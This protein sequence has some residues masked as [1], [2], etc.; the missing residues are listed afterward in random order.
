MLL[1]QV[2]LVVVVV[3]IVIVAI[4]V[5]V[6]I[7]SGVMQLLTWSIWRGNYQGTG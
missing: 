5:G 2:M 3:V 1:L 7:C 4:G 6:T